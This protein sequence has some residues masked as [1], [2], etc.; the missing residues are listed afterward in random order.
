MKTLTKIV[1]ALFMLTLMIGMC[2]AADNEIID[3][4]EELAKV[5]RL[6]IYYPNYYHYEEYA[7]EPPDVNSFMKVLFDAGR[8]SKNTIISYDE[9]TD[10]IKMDYGIDMKV[11]SKIEAR[12]VFKSHAYQYSDAYVVVTVANNSRVAMFFDVYA[13]NTNER[14]YSFQVSGGKSNGDKTVRAYQTLAEQFYRAF[15]KAVQE[16]AK[17]QNKK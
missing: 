12:K 6:A 5:K 4:E 1:A 7:G 3:N 13:V 2:E 17:N 8:V 11:L 14:L 15:D 16:S 10:K 9:M